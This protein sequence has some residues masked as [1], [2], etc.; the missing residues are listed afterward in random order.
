MRMMIGTIFASVVVSAFGAV[1]MPAAS[2]RQGATQH[3]AFV[4]VVDSNYVPASDLRSDE[5]KVLEDGIARPV[6]RVEPATDSMQTVLSGGML[7]NSVATLS[8]NSPARLSEVTFATDANDIVQT[9]DRLVRSHATRPVVIADFD[10]RRYLVDLP[11]VVYTY[12]PVEQALQRAGASLWVLVQQSNGPSPP[13]R[14]NREI[15]QQA[16]RASGG[17]FLLDGLTPE[18]TAANL[19]KIR[20]MLLHQYRVTF[21][22]PDSAKRPTTFDV[23]VSRPGTSVSAPSWPPQ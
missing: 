16:T 9:C 23:K 5:V 15:Y 14:L 6:L 3:F 21:A 11:G 1:S 20:T 12:L 13:N 8:E 17:R 10:E 18:D 19:E 4:S 2:Q 22:R 7:L